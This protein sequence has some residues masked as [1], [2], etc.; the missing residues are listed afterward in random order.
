MSKVPRLY[1][2]HCT[3]C[4]NNVMFSYTPLQQPQHVLCY[5]CCLVY[6]T[7]N[8]TM[9]NDNKDHAQIEMR[10][11]N[12]AVK[13]HQMQGEFRQGLNIGIVGR[14]QKRNAE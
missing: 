11:F 8:D 14:M 10:R 3:E 7:A 6:A 13:C 4:G 1:A 5:T 12:V 9:R 2:I